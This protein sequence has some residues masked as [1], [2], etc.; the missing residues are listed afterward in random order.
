VNY[1]FPFPFMDMLHGT[2]RGGW[3]GYAWRERKRSGVEVAAPGDRDDAS[4]ASGASSRTRHARK[5]R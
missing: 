5:R 3:G 1:A 2:Y 4:A